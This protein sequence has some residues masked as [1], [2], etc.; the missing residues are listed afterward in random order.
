MTHY[1]IWQG[2]DKRMNMECKVNSMTIQLVATAADPSIHF[3]EFTHSIPLIT[4]S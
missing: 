3:S 4:V 2:E 1:L